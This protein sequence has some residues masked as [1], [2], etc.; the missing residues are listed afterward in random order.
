MTP[1]EIAQWMREE[2]KAVEELSQRLRDR[3]A[4]VPRSGLKHWI[5]AAGAQLD[6]FQIH[7]NK[8]FG[9]EEAGG[10]LEAV[11]R[12]SPAL[13]PQVDRLRHEHDEIVR[14]LA[15]IH[16]ELVT[17]TDQDR[18]LIEDCCCRVQNLLRYIKDHEEREDVIVVSVFTRDFGDEG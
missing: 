7:L 14:I 8:H 9:L 17:L 6:D 5:E 12:R 3:V 16:R 10:Y 15:S 2:H 1:E 18:I 13:S 11:V 4:T